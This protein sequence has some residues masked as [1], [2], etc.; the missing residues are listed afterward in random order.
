MFDQRRYCNCRR[1]PVA[2]GHGRRHCTR[3][4]FFYGLSAILVGGGL[5][6][7]WHL[8]ARAK[9][10]L[11]R[12][13]D[14]LARWQIDAATWSDFKTLNDEINRRPECLFNELSI[15]DEVPTEG[16]EIIVGKTAIQIDGSIH[17]FPAHST[18]EVTHSQLHENLTG[19][20]Y[21]ELLLYYPG[22]GHG[23]SG[24]PIRPTRTAVRF[25]VVGT[26][27]RD[28]R[29]IVAHFGGLL[30]GKPDIFHGTGD[31]NNPEDLSRCWSC[32]Y[33]TYIYKSHCPECG[34]TLQSKRW[35]RRFGFVLSLCGLFIT[36]LMGT[37]SYYMVPQ[38]LQPGVE[39]NGS[40]FSGNTTQAFIVLGIF[41][42]VLSFGA[43]A[44][45]YGLW[46]MKTGKRN[47]RV[48]YS[49]VG[50]FGIFALVAM[51]MKKMGL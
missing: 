38:L 34:S 28:A 13:E 27:W 31:G 7:F 4:S 1:F 23:A 14:I 36:G 33:E 50:I 29:I 44:M 22:G 6:L 21:I 26:A 12:G 25:P 48:V 47:I 15:R 42:L 46:Q 39:I 10:A 41:G 24:V 40:R 49:M 43:S 2:V 37:V 32:G 16:I 45:F 30:P 18:P 5:A 8:D 3:R 17:R 35:S 19:P 9:A 51:L 20:S 11:A